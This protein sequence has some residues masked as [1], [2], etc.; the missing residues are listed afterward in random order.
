MRQC[1]EKCPVKELPQVKQH[2]RFK[3][4]IMRMPIRPLSRWLVKGLCQSRLQ[5]LLSAA[6]HSVSPPKTL[7]ANICVCFVQPSSW[8]SGPSKELSYRFYF[9]PYSGGY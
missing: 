9:D 1:P 7:L 4:V 3:L 5:V 6:E 2:I 8:P